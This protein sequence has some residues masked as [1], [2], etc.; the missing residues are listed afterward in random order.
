[1]RR[2]ES[3]IRAGLVLFGV[4]VSFVLAEA[5]VRTF[6][7]N[8]RDSVVPGNL[9]VID[10]GLGW[11]LAPSKTSNHRTRYFDATY[12]TN[13]AGFRDKT[14]SSPGD[15]GYRMVLYGDSQ[16]FG[17]GLNEGK[18]FADIVEQERSGL[19][20][21]NRSVPGYGL[22]QEVISYE[23][24]SPPLTDEVL[25]LVSPSTLGR[26]H[27]RF[28]YAK[29]KP[30]FVLERSGSLEVL[31]VPRGRN[32]MIDVLYRVLSPFY[33]PYFLQ[34]Q[35]AILRQTGR[36][37][38]SGPTSGTPA[39]TTETS[40][41]HELALAILR[42]ASNVARERN[43]R[44]TLLLASLPPA[45]LSTMLAFCNEIGVTY[46]EIDPSRPIGT[47]PPISVDE[48]IFGEGDGHWNAKAN[49]IIAAQLLSQIEDRR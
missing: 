47:T 32:A 40:G 3:L 39:V 5:F 2:R 20:I 17:W 42:R 15:P 34:T 41:I 12:N 29:Y 14:R 4:A 16:A 18:R 43:H 9:F 38:T 48:A 24:D 44:L 1:M 6:Y 31:A 11:R 25:V 21:W 7:P 22:D 13:S 19:E 37:A 36:S 46:L 28:N 27:S 8:A 10:D 49:G 23:K 30:M 45:D 35:M 26:I 33:L